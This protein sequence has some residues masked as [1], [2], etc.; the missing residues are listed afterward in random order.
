M[1]KNHIIAGLVAVLLIGGLGIA[2]Q[3]LPDT[4]SEGEV[5]ATF[6]PFYD[7]TR[8]IAGAEATDYL[9]PPGTDPHHFEPTVSDQQK[10]DNAEIVVTTGVEFEEW[11][12]TMMAG[13]DHD[14]HVIAAADGIDLIAAEQDNH[15]HSGH[16]DTGHDTARDDEHHEDHHDESHEEHD[17]HN[18]RQHEADD[19]HD[20]HDHG[21]NDPHYWVSP[22]NAVTIAETIR[23]G[24]VAADPGNADTYRENAAEYIQAL[25]ELDAAYEE[26][27]SGCERD[28]VITSHA[29]FAYLG[30]DYGFSQIPILGLSTTSEPSPQQ[31]QELVDAAE[32]HGLEHVF[33]ETTVNPS[34]SETIAEE[35]DGETLQL[36]PVAAVADPD[37]DT[38][39]SV[40]ED[41]LANLEVALDC[42]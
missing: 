14:P 5:V 42:R 39:I 40:M 28:H 29:A 11:E 37:E 26:R 23:D 30:H 24:L 19:G 9:V 16:A 3:T 31:M 36:D 33:F 34:V 4:D 27:L 32:E 35:I 20:D 21:P 7:I 18:E 38:Y 10:L 1:Q 12:T 2:S 22:N 17:G 15:P 41:N 8:N 25:Q 13:L 6:Y